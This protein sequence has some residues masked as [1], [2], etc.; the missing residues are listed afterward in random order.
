MEGTLGGGRTVEHDRL[1]G[2]HWECFVCGPENPRGLRLNIRLVNDQIETEFIPTADLQGPPGVVH[3][4]IVAGVLD[5]VM[6][7]LI[8]SRLVPAVTRKIEVTYRRP[9]RVGVTYRITAEVSGENRRIVTAR[10]EARD[11]NGVQVARA[12]GVFAPLDEEKVARFL[13]AEQ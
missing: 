10:A 11:P 1:Q 5:E 7:Q 2:L 9:M 13:N 12:R 4:G 6:S 3:S 8:Y